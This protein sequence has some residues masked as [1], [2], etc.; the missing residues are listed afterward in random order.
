MSHLQNEEVHSYAEHRHHRFGNGDTAMTTV[1]PAPSGRAG[2]FQES[3]KT[4]G[5]F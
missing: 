3:F 5:R 1:E 4:P 2:R